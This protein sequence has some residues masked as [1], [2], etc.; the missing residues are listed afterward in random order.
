MGTGLSNLTKELGK[1][2]GVLGSAPPV[3]HSSDPI[4]PPT[5][6]IDV[7]QKNIDQSRQRLLEAGVEEAL[8]DEAE[9]QA[10]PDKNAF[11]KAFDFVQRPYY[12]FAGGLTGLVD[13]K[14]KDGFMEGFERG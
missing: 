5:S 11:E 9:A 8:I 3:L 4:N 7:A 2:K 13:D 10:T 12:A 1:T 14:P 6:E